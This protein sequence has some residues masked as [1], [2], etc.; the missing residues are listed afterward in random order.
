MQPVGHSAVK[1]ALVKPMGAG[2]R[3]TEWMVRG[4]PGQCFAM[5]HL[6][7]TTSKLPRRLGLELSSRNL[8]MRPWVPSPAAGEEI[9]WAF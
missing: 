4:I 2:M 1:L 9:T 3:E 7:A 6:K 5:S 8:E